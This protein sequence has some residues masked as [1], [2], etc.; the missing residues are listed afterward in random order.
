MGIPE[1]WL[2]NVTERCIEIFRQVMGLRT[3]VRR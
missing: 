1:V 2:I 3:I